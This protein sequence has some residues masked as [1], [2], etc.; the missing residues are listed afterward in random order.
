[1]QLLTE[2]RDHAALVAVG[3]VRTTLPP[4]A[5]GCSVLGL[6]A[7]LWAELS[8]ALKHCS[9]L[10]CSQPATLASV[11]LQGQGDGWWQGWDK[12]PVQRWGWG[13]RCWLLAW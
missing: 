8:C 9:M 13:S 10:L 3:Q 2:S 4:P 11:S 6:C 12:S 7:G 5:R 1:M